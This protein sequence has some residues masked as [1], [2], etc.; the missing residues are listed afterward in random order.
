MKFYKYPKT[1]D[2]AEYVAVGDTITQYS[3]V[4]T[5]SYPD[6][7]RVMLMDNA[8]SPT[9][10]RASFIPSQGEIEIHEMEFFEA[11]RV[12]MISLYEVLQHSMV[13]K[14]NFEIDEATKHI[15]EKVV[16]R[17]LENLWKGSTSQTGA[18][19]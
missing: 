3:D 2:V 10:E 12:A 7:I 17:F 9:I 11:Y 1:G 13:Y 5:N 14:V 8:N 4:I 19:P 6:C 16:D 18:A 15:R